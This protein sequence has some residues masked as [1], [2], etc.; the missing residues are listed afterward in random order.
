MPDSYLKW[1]YHPTNNVREFWLVHILTSTW[2]CLFNFDQS[3]GCEVVSHYGF[4]LYFN[5]VEY[6]FICLLAICICHI[7]SLVQLF[8]P[9]KNGLFA[10]LILDLQEF[11]KYSGD[12]PLSDIR[13]FGF[14]N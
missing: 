7:Y 2:Y 4:N 8:Y 13:T 10:F 14:E 6:L 1:F 9:F 12:N 3:S 11:S 5:D